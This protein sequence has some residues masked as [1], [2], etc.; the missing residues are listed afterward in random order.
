M[1]ERERHPTL[2]FA[3]EEVRRYLRLAGLAEESLPG[4]TVELGEPSG[5]DAY[6]IEGDAE[7]IAIRGSNPRSALIGAYAYLKEIGFAF[8][9]PGEDY[10]RIPRLTDSAQLRVPRRE[11]RAAHSFRGMCIEGAESLEQMLAYIDWL[12]KAG[13][14]ICFAQFFRPDVF[15]ERWYSHQNNP[16][17]PPR[18][19]SEE[20]KKAFDRT[21][22]AEI[23]KRGLLLHRAGHGWTSRA[24]GYPGNGWQRQEEPR[25]ARLRS[26]IALLKGERRLFGGVPANTN[27]CYASED[28]QQALTDDVVAY[29]KAHPEVD[30]VHFWLADTFNNLCECE[31]C[32]QTTLSDQYVRILN[33]IDSALTEAG[34]ATR[35][36]F[37]LYQELLYPPERERIR[38]PERFILM[39]APISRTFETGYPAEAPAGEL[40]PYRRNAMRLPLDIGENLRYYA[41]WRQVFAGDAFIYDY[42]LGRAHYGDPGYLKI[43]G[44]LCGDLRRVRDLGFQGLIAC[45]E[46]RV[47]MPNALPIYAMGRLLWDADARPE[48]VAEAY[49]EG[50]YGADAPRVRTY[51]EAVSALCDTDYANAN[52]PRLRPDLTG[53]YREIARLSRM[54]SETLEDRGD[55]ILR[56]YGSTLLQNAAYAD[57]LAALTAGDEAAAT[58]AYDRYCRIIR[59]REAVYPMDFDVYRAIEVTQRYTGL[60][61]TPCT[62]TNDEPTTERDERV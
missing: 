51:F 26:R 37:L 55:P 31:A 6:A 24:L 28:V 18:L 3:A 41:A 20:E 13:M 27:L 38:H 48:D 8:W 15:W 19:L 53:R 33:R 21:L 12:P 16:L 50:L 54:E 45:Q 32:R 49:F 7:R 1:T 44:T 52:G 58:A 5:E 57:A 59:E 43:V 60:K 17:M 9:A 23:K 4:I 61:E 30:A 47:M 11:S 10:T 42:H 40:P 2:A 36:V 25:E 14:N 29:A 39:F 22:T 56:R 46:L 62:P 35:I 34:L